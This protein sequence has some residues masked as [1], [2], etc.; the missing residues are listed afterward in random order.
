MIAPFPPDEVDRLTA[1]ES[2]EILDTAPE[3]NLD[4]IA[5][6]ASVICRSPISAIT[7]IDRDRQWFK[8]SVGLSVTETARED[9]FCA[10]TI[11]TSDM[12][13]VEDATRDPR[14]S[15]NPHVTGEPKIRFYAG[16]PLITPENFR[17][18]SLCVIDRT[19]RSL[20]TEE[21]GALESL[22][23]LIVTELELRRISRDLAHA[24]REVK[25]LTGLVPICSYCKD[26]R[27]DKGYWNRVE[28]YFTQK[29]GADFSHGLCPKC[30]KIHFPEATPEP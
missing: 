22:S 9:A 23:R 11:L 10:H 5:K 30:A 6:I 25:S 26:I 3:R 13:I 20:T 18:G 16:A 14:F 2:Y 7:F 29:T 28:E 15:D 12:L 19:P 24:V 27:D 17:L 8:A 4:D 21:R 1:L